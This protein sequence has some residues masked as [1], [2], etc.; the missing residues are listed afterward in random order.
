MGVL[1]EIVST[2]MMIAAIAVAAYSLSGTWPVMVAVETE[3]MVPHINPGDLVFITKRVNITTYEEGVK[4]NYESFGGYGD[5]IVYMPDGDPRKIPIIHRCMKW[6]EKGDKMP[7]WNYTVTY[8]GY[9]TL[10][11]NNRGVY[12]RVL[13]KEDWVVGVAVFKIP[14]IGYIPIAFYRLIG[15]GG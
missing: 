14:Y 3:S 12:D 11:D 1:R 10:G 13:V 2:L 8:S 9:A 7:F 4:I 15:I 5:V 6:V